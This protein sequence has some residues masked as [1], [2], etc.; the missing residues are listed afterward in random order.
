MTFSGSGRQCPLRLCASRTGQEMVNATLVAHIHGFGVVGRR[1]SSSNKKYKKYNNNKKGRSRRSN[2]PM[3][4][5]RSIIAVNWI[6][7]WMCQDLR[8]IVSPS[9]WPPYSPLLPSYI[10]R[11]FFD[12]F[13]HMFG[14]NKIA[15]SR[16]ATATL[17]LYCSCCCMLRAKGQKN[18][19]INR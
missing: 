6:N 9:S 7:N 18:I 13:S 16:V 14:T 15:A 11:F 12:S 19:H 17:T 5:P 4:I 2:Q 3:G 8:R 1:S 10:L